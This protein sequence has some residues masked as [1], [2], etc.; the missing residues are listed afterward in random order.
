[1][2]AL[3]GYSSLLLVVGLWTAFERMRIALNA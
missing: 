2:W 1:M 3:V